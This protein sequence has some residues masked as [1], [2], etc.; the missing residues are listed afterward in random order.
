MY[1]TTK[2]K[3]KETFGEEWWRADA[4]KVGGERANNKK[5]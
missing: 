2:E 5:I 1:L 4:K 3:A